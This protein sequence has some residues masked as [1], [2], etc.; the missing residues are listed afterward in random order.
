MSETVFPPAGLDAHVWEV[1]VPGAV[2]NVR[3][4]FSAGEP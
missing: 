2:A 3:H 4:G 1:E